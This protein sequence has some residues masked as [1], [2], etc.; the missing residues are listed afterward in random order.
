M[1]CGAAAGLFPVLLPATNSSGESITI[2]TALA[3]PHTLRVGVVWWTFGIMLALLYFGT[4]YW[5]FRGKVPQHADTY[6]H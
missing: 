6:G 4:V 1:L 5:L 2:A 3:G